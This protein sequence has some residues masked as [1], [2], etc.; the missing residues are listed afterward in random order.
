MGFRPLEPRAGVGLT[1]MSLALLLVLRR[2]VAFR[3]SP[4]PAAAALS[5][6]RDRSAAAGAAA[7][8]AV[9]SRHTGPEGTELPDV[10]HKA[11]SAD[12]LKVG[13]VDPRTV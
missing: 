7:A 12:G 2:G 5:R 1:A 8:G 4:T 13:I 6:G 9:V 3:S 10:M 11:V